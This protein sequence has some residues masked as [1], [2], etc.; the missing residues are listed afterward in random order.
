[1]FDTTFFAAKFCAGLAIISALLLTG[2]VSGSRSVK[3]DWDAE[4]VLTL[5]KN[6]EAMRQRS[7]EIATLINAQNTHNLEVSNAHQ[8]AV[9]KLNL[10]LATAISSTHSAGGLR[11]SAAACAAPATVTSNT[12]STGRLVPDIAGTIALPDQITDDLLRLASEADHVTEIA[13]ACQKWIIANGMY[14]VN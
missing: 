10:N 1:V 14:K 5:R 4:K 8:I 7:Q 11:I 6:V 3:A 13:R 2:Y 9:D 12:A